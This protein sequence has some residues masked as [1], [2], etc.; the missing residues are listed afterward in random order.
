[1]RSPI[2][3]LVMLCAAHGMTDTCAPGAL[4]PYGL[5]A[6]PEGA[7]PGWLITSLFGAASIVHFASDLGVALSFVMHAVLSL[8][9]THNRDASFL[10]MS[11]YF[12]LVH[13]PLHYLRLL[14]EGRQLAVCSAVSITA[15]MAVICAVP[16]WA[17]YWT[18]ILPNSLRLLAPF[19]DGTAKGELHIHVTHTMQKL[20]VA[21]V[22]VEALHRTSLGEAWLPSLSPPWQQEDF[23]P[24]RLLRKSR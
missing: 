16:Q 23:A 8:A 10:A 12:S 17:A 5:L 21:H 24:L 11:I 9:A 3:R 2:R 4:A 20:V 7:M 18:R 19:D 15:L 13:T 1:M 22:L 14:V 6:V